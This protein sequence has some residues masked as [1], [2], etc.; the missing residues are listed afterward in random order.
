MVTEF[1]DADVDERSSRTPVFSV[2]LCDDLSVI[3][4]RENQYI[5][6]LHD[7]DDP[8]RKRTTWDYKSRHI[9][10]IRSLIENFI[11]VFTDSGAEVFSL[12]HD[13]L[14]GCAAVT[15]TSHKHVVF[16]DMIYSELHG[17]VGIW[18]DSYEPR[19]EKM[20]AGASFNRELK[21][22]IEYQSM[23]EENAENAPD[24]TL[25]LVDKD[26]LLLKSKRKNT[27]SRYI[28]ATARKRLSKNLR[29]PS[30]GTSKAP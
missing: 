3:M 14:D 5:V 6:A 23:A 29:V 4:A 28:C 13:A 21:V 9:T 10:R 1:A 7:F 25:I 18:Y 2:L 22:D 16:A 15:H 12:R 8:T 20:A 27:F 24:I 26:L 11:G 17:V 30:R 19:F